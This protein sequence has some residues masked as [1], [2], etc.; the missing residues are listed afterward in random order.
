MHSTRRIGIVVFTTFLFGFCCWI[1]CVSQ[2]KYWHET[3]VSEFTEL[4]KA[5]RENVEASGNNSAKYLLTP[6]A[7]LPAFEDLMVALEAEEEPAMETR[8][9]HL[10][11]VDADELALLLRGLYP[12]TKIAPYFEIVSQSSNPSELLQV[13][14]QPQ[15]RTRSIKVCTSQKN[16]AHIAQLIGKLDSPHSRRSGF[17]FSIGDPVD[18]QT[19]QKVLEDLFR[20][21]VTRPKKSTAAH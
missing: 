7:I 1:A 10:V 6:G 12:S 14:V 2:S 3:H 9:F 11:R 5:L 18:P 8:E 4:T 17:I 19:V 16:L 13:I 21:N 15:L 20:T